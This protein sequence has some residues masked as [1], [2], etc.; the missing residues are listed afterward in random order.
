MGDFQ[1]GIRNHDLLNTPPHN[2]ADIFVSKSVVRTALCCHLLSTVWPVHFH[3]SCWL[4][5]GFPWLP[6]DLSFS[7]YRPFFCSPFTPFLAL[8]YTQ[9]S[10]H[11]F[12]FASY[13]STR[14]NFVAFYL[15]FYFILPSHY[16][17]RTERQLT[18]DKTPRSLHF[19]VVSI[20][21]PSFYLLQTLKICKNN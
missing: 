7:D 4:A 21:F 10:R 1:A 3:C 12:L 11:L 13:N 5:L 2:N 17:S 19:E 20:S 6:Q 16:T 8:I 15:P 9:S 18:Q 14:S